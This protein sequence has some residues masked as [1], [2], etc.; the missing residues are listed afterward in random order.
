MLWYELKSW[1][2]WLRCGSCQAKAVYLGI[3][4]GM[5]LANEGRCC[6]VTSSVIGRGPA[7]NDPRISD[8]IP[9]SSCILNSSEAFA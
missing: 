7:Q 3:I 8:G 1:E 6:N 9:V 5:G 4:L 2:V